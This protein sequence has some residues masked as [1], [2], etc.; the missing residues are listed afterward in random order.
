MLLRK[1]LNILLR[2]LIIMLLGEL[3]YCIV[4]SKIICVCVCALPKEYIYFMYCCMLHEIGCFFFC[5]VK[6][7][8]IEF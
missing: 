7:V 2:M 1:G 5:F 8:T 4:C 3:L 6:L